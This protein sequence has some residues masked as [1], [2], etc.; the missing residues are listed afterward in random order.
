MNRRCLRT[1]RRPTL[2]HH[3]SPPE[4]SRRTQPTRCRRRP[5]RDQP[6]PLHQRDQL[7]PQCARPAQPQRKPRRPP[8]TRRAPGA[9]TASRPSGKPTLSV[10]ELRTLVTGIDRATLGG[11]RDPVFIL[12]G[13]AGALRIGELAHSPWTTS[14]RV[15]T[16]SSCGSA[17]P[18]PTA[19]PPA[20]RSPSRC[21]CAVPGGAARNSRSST[22]RSRCSIGRPCAGVR[23]G[24]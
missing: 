14:N 18:R 9:P 4:T 11:A 19:T 6:Q 17:A 5:R 1:H 13:Y 2:R 10:A 21:A 22:H 24:I 16:A 7:R 20:P 3:P 23:T 12:I 8:G 15:P